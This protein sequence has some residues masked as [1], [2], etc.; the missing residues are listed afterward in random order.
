MTR[1]TQQNKGGINI[2][3]MDEGWRRV[4]IYIQENSATHEQE[5]NRLKIMNYSGIQY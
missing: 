5:R 3:M 4:S 2:S 1:L